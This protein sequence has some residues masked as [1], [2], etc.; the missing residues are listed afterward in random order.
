MPGLDHPFSPRVASHLSAVSMGLA[1]LSVEEI[2]RLALLIRETM[3]N[4]KSVFIGGNGGS[5]ALSQHFA[6]D[7]LKSDL[8]YFPAGVKVLAIG[9]NSASST[10]ISNDFGF[11]HSF[12]YEIKQ[13]GCPGDLAVLFSCSGSSPNIVEAIKV[14]KDK[15]MVSVLVSSELCPEDSRQL[16]TE[17]VLV[18]S[19]HYGVIEDLHQ[20]IAHSVAFL[21]REG[22]R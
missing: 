11:L 1:A 3:S 17:T 8:R 9:A 19:S 22:N 12:A 15:E 4:G 16:A 21:F 14:T 5:Q 6:C 20:V 2:E 7:L 18:P 13:Q 10:M